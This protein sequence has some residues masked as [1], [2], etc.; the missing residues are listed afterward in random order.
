MCICKNLEVEAREPRGFW[1]QSLIDGFDGS[2]EDQNADR[3]IGN[4]ACAFDTLGDSEGLLGIDH[5]LMTQ[6][7]LGRK[8]KEQKSRKESFEIFRICSEIP[9]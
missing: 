2:S 8:N 3:C 9:K 7:G 1:K 6:W 5:T 4:K